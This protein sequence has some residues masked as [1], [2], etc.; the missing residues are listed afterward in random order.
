M[1]RRK[2]AKVL[3]VLNKVR[4]MK[5]GFFLLSLVGH[6]SDRPVQGQPQAEGSLHPAKHRAEEALRNT[7]GSHQ[8]IQVGK[9]LRSQTK[10]K[11]IFRIC[12]FQIHF[13]PRRQDRRPVQQHQARLLPAVRR[14]DDHSAPLPPKG[15]AFIFKYAANDIWEICNFNL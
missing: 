6:P 3:S 4:K 13:H 8:R 14:R 5:R 1:K 12:F 11:L 9:H 10:F 2:T 15:K 7:W